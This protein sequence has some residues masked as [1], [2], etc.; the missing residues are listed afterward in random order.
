MTR[1][2]DLRAPD[3][4]G[5]SATEPLVLERFVPFRVSVLSR[6][7]SSAL[8]RCYADRFQLTIPE[9][10]VMAVLGLDG[11]LSAADVCARTLMDKVTVSRAVARLAS[12]KR[13]QRRTD[14][15]DLRRS[16]LRLS[17][18]GRAVYRRGLKSD[19]QRITARY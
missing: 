16:L 7:L 6:R 18:D 5:A 1:V 17:A 10:R 19:T 8:S 2:L 13:V 4:R 3:P 9:W 14:P 15:A 11:E 12:M